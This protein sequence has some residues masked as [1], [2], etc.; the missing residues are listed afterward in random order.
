MRASQRE[1]DKLQALAGRCL[2]N[3]RE[4][5]VRRLRDQ[6]LP[7]S[8]TVERTIVVEYGEGSWGTESEVCQASAFQQPGIPSAIRQPSDH[9]AYGTFLEQLTPLALLVDEMSDLGEPQKEGFM[10]SLTGPDGIIQRNLAGMCVAYL[11]GLSDLD[12]PDPSALERLASELVELCSRKDIA[13]VHQ[14]VISGVLVDEPIDPCNDVRIRALS[15]SERGSVVERQTAGLS[16]GP[17]HHIELAIPGPGSLFNPTALLEVMSTHSKDRPHEEAGLMAAV[18]LSLYLHGFDLQ[19]MGVVTSFEIPKWASSSIR[20]NSFPLGRKDLPGE[21]RTISPNDFATVV[22]LATKIPDFSAESNGHQI[23]LSRVL[24]GCATPDSGLLDFAIA[25]EAALLGDANS[26]LAYRFAL[27]G[28]LFLAGERSP[29]ETFKRL[30]S[31]YRI[32]SKLVHGSRVNDQE[33]RIAEQDAGQLAK[34]VVLRA[35]EHGWPSKRQLDKKA[36]ASQ[37]VSARN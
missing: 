18:C 10:P 26:E 15:P 25:L 36:L 2:K 12:I 17:S 24:R 27:Y 23:A 16:S 31:L 30:A 14:L 20:G 32:R 13:R 4:W 9:L 34:A 5:T 28:A 11:A 6:G 7:T 22:E 29:E 1:L 8:V 21:Q 35:L 33:R 37:A 3:A 19:S